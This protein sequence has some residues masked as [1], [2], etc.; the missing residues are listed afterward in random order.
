RA[1][2]ETCIHFE[3]MRR[4]LAALD[5]SV[6]TTPVL[7]TAIDLAKQYRASLV[8]FRAVDVPPE[9]P[10][11]AAT[12]HA[13]ELGPKLLAD[14]RRDLDELASV[15]RSLG[16][17][18]STDVVAST[19]PWR[20]IIDA[21][22]SRDA[23]AIVVG[24]HGYRVIDRLLGTTAAR[25]ADRAKTLVIVVHGAPTESAAESAGPYRTKS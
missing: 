8:L 11:A 2:I 9:F 17:E 13:D 19:E 18:T 7:R 25:V 6:R 16:V 21:A 24:S 20:A 23:D 12:H 4:I 22:Q 5:V 14:A 10:P 1:W 15:A 3:T